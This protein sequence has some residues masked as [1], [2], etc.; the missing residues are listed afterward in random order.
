MSAWHFRR[1]F[2]RA[3]SSC[4][5]ERTL[6][7]VHACHLGAAAPAAIVAAGTGVSL[8]GLVKC[9]QRLEYS[10]GCNRG[11]TNTS[12]STCLHIII[13]AVTVVVTIVTIVTIVTAAAVAT[14][15]S[16]PSGLDGSSSLPAYT[17]RYILILKQGQWS[18][19][20]RLNEGA[21]QKAR[22]KTRSPLCK[23]CSPK[24][25]EGLQSEARVRERRA[26][27]RNMLLMFFFRFGMHS[28]T[29]VTTERMLFS[30][31][32]N[33]IPV[34]PTRTELPHHTHHTH[35]TKLTANKLKAACHKAEG[36]R[37]KEHG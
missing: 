26:T 28:T 6:L 20:V 5:R 17:L 4:T 37:Q 24:R 11:Y 30:K 19:R 8:L 14:D 27:F 10:L 3:A 7:P 1:S 21:K 32:F 36:T 2:G 31:C 13:A 25:E 33:G 15:A 34:S 22:N 12:T 23:T 9:P 35:H 29:W 16:K 18:R